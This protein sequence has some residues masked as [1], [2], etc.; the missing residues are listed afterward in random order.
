MP[1]KL[2][3]RKRGGE[4]VCVSALVCLGFFLGIWIIPLLFVFAYHVAP[5]TVLMSCFLL[6]CI[7]LAPALA[8]SQKGKELAG[9]N[10][11]ICFLA[12][13]MGL[14]MYYAQVQPARSLM[15][16][17][18]YRN[19]YPQQPAAG[20]S[21]AVILEFA[22]GTLVDDTK[23]VGMMDLDGGA[24]TYCVAPIGDHTSSGRYEFWAIGVDCCGKRSA[25][26]CGDAGLD[27]ARTG[28]VVRDPKQSDVLYEAF[29][30]YV[31]PPMARRDLFMK[32]VRMAEYSHEIT[33][34]KDPIFVQWTNSSKLELMEGLWEKIA[35]I[36][37]VAFVVVGFISFGLMKAKH[38][39]DIK[40]HF[41]AAGDAYA[42]A[43]WDALGVMESARESL[44]QH[45]NEMAGMNIATI[46]LRGFVYPFLL[47]MVTVLVWSWAFCFSIGY[48]VAGVYL[49]LLAVF[50]GRLATQVA[51]STST[52]Y[53]IYL[54][55]VVVAALQT[56]RTNWYSNT[57]HYCADRSRRSYHN[58][59]PSADPATMGDAGRVYFDAEAKLNATQSVGLLYRGTTYCAAPVVDQAMLNG[60][61]STGTLLGAST[62][63]NAPITVSFWAI[64]RDC[65][66]SRGNFKCDGAELS[67]GAGLVYHDYA[68]DSRAWSWLFARHNPELDQF[69]RAV[70]ASSHLHNF[71]LPD[72]PILIRYV[73][74]VNYV[75]EGRLGRAFG[76]CLLSALVAMIAL[77]VISLAF[78]V[79]L[80]MN[81]PP[82]PRDDEQRLS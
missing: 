2:V 37:A 46:V 79:W 66:D 68:D 4:T 67:G 17:R 60:T 80:R 40:T 20:H 24:A 6:F 9:A 21:D 62:A 49:L 11:V 35:I 55:L 47:V 23:T 74:D 33:S 7:A 3:G 64:G 53:S 76:I 63:G 81:K 28:F 12:F 19:V 50:A 71:A 38:A 10:F 36:L 39:G 8:G 5:G 22:P 42:S 54:A 41:E 1:A 56:G 77:G 44:N 16:W 45:Q 65:C 26:S 52:M 14:H 18:T 78:F 32:A 51:N 59:F 13:T 31:A 69:R 58:V 75:Q 48:V 29:G 25:F 43:D 57:F 73:G 15:D 34:A 30:K 27:G 61:R 72:S 70:A 82:A